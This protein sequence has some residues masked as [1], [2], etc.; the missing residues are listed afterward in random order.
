MLERNSPRGASMKT[1]EIPRPFRIETHR[2]EDDGLTPNVK[3][4]GLFKNFG[5]G[6][7]C[8][9]A[10]E[11]L[12]RLQIDVRGREERHRFSS[13]RVKMWPGVRARVRVPVRVPNAL[14]CCD[15]ARA[16]KFRHRG[17]PPDAF[18]HGDL[19]HTRAIE[20]EMEVEFG[21][22]RYI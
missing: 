13:F 3:T 5:T 17:R 11:P 9:Q 21:G 20:N 10:L 8:D 19:G 2:D 22:A 15:Y 6:L 16:R 14:R 4:A 18:G 1:F 12:S 7:D